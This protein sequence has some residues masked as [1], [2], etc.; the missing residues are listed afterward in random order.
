MTAQEAAWRALEDHA[1]R[2]SGR[3]LRDLVAQGPER[4]AA[5]T[6][7]ACGLTLDLA[8]ERLDGAAMD[9]LIALARAGRVEAERDDMAS[10]RPVNATEGRAA[11]HM[12]L[13]GG[14]PPP[15]GADAVGA[16]DRFLAFAESVRSGAF[17]GRGGAITDVVNIGIGGSDLGPAMAARALSPFLDGP[18]LHFASNIDGAHFAD[19][20]R[21]LDPA[22]TLAVVC[23][24][25]FTTQETTANALLARNWLGAGEAERM[26]AV[27]AN[28]SACRA[29]GIPEDR[30]FGLWD[31]VG[32]RYSLWSAAGLALAIGIGAENFRAFLAGA[33]AMDR[34]FLETPL[35]ANLPVLYALSGIWRRNLL[36][37]GATALIPYG[38][39]LSRLVAHL[40]QL[41][42]ESLGKRVDKR[43][44]AL[45]RPGAPVLWGAPGTDAQHSFFQML[46]QGGEIVPVDF[47]AAAQ[48]VAAD[49]AHHRILLANCLAQGQ[50][51]AF[52]RSQGETEA[53]MRASGASEEDIA[54]LAPHRTFPGN[55]PSTTILLDRLDPETLGA[56]IAFYEHKV[57]TQAA[58]WGVNP[59]DQWGVELGKTLAARLLPA[60]ETGDTGGLDP[61]TAAL[62]ER[63]R[64]L[65]GGG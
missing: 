1:A 13:R 41:E 12:A 2:L 6:A 25:T 27:S 3:S 24:K 48:P 10:G 35:E 38:H 39:R 5:L 60:L 40:Q 18:A 65:D 52:G 19:A 36:G 61:A 7:R 59:F 16:R 42:L 4:C 58:I 28:P 30:V 44:R 34:H 22:R 62:A 15:E 51:L 8:K 49:P 55:R 54:R 64:G 53:E 17:R 47:I 46:H 31:W 11:L 21:G 23:S 33:A 63:V 29:F 26:V 20:V 57:F 43:G 14:V 32:G 56:L 50:A 37:H 45:P 9:G